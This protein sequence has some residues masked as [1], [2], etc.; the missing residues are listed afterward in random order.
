[1]FT[2]RW[3]AGRA[4]QGPREV[5]EISAQAPPGK[6]YLGPRRLASVGLATSAPRNGSESQGGQGWQLWLHL[7]VP[8]SLPLRGGVAPRVA[9]SSE[10]GSSEPGVRAVARPQIP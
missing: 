3:L 7:T 6:G 8:A 5:Q 10:A 2:T 9:W 1:M 4:G